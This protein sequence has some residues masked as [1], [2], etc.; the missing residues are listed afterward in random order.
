VTH[1]FPELLRQNA[2]LV[3]AALTAMMPAAGDTQL[4]EAMRYAVLNG[5]KRLRGF[6][7]LESA[8]LFDVP[9]SQSLRVAA[10]IECVH[11]YSLVHD[12][13]PCMDDDA[14]R[15]GKPTVHIKWDEAT[16]VL[17][18]DALQTLAF[19]FLADAETSPSAEV[20]LALISRLAS[21]AGADGMVLGQAQDIAAE[22]AKAP[23]DL[24]QITQ[25]QANKT[26]A[27][28]EWSAISG[29]VLAQS[30]T[31]PL[32]KY[33]RALGLAFQ[34][35][36]DILDVEGDSESAGKR[37]NK[38]ADAGKATFVSL[39]GL[40]AARIRAKS[41]VEEASDMLSPYGGGAAALR[42]VAQYVIS[43]DR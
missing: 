4:S 24:S 40:E 35:Q 13:L 8:R 23:L 1:P 41:L 30:D 9:D 20:R 15:R 28:I 12:D 25:L 37:L 32:E 33:A 14:L 31:A 19:E 21:A 29:A 34:I 18:G 26:G 11:A 2:A 36:D 17:V 39:L 43:R 7:A 10:A 38:D 5:G 22:T 3:E 27:L 6:L 16:A 42:Q